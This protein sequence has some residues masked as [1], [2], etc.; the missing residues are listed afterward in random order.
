MRQLAIIG[1][2][3]SHL[4]NNVTARHDQIAW[5]G[6]GAIHEFRKLRSIV[7]VACDL[8]LKLQYPLLTE[9]VPRRGVFPR[10]TVGARFV[11]PQSRDDVRMQVRH[12]VAQQCV[13]DSSG[14]G[15]F[16]E[17]TTDGLYVCHE[18]VEQVRR[19]KGEVLV[20]LTED[21]EA[22]ARETVVVVESNY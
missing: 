14:S 17:C 4:S 15:S 10:R 9:R 2:A 16:V 19:E 3:A 6:V 1:E 18:Q 5:R 7:E 8:T 21:D 22:A 11:G 20:V 12:H 13:V